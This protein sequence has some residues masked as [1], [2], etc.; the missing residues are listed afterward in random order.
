MTVATFYGVDGIGVVMNN[1]DLDIVVSGVSIPSI[2]ESSHR[3]SAPNYILQYKYAGFKVDVLMEMGSWPYEVMLANYY[4]SSNKV[5]ASIQFENKFASDTKYPNMTDLFLGDDKINGSKYADEL[6]GDDGNDVISGDEGNDTLEGGNG[7]DTL[8]GGPGEDTAVYRRLSTDYIITTSANGDKVIGYPGNYDTL[9]SIE[10]AQFADKTIA[11]VSNAPGQTLDG[12][13]ANDSLT[14]GVSNDAIDGKAGR[15]T[16]N[17][18]SKAAAYAVTPNATSGNASISGPEGSDSLTSI[19]RI[20]FA[21]ACLAFDLEGNAGQIYRLYKAAYA[22]TPDLG[23]LGNWIANLDSGAKTLGQAA[24]EFAASPE[25]NNLYGAHTSNETFVTLLYQNAMGR[26]PDSAGLA[27]YV[28]ALDAGTLTRGAALLSFS[29]SQE[30]QAAVSPKLAGGILYATSEQMLQQGSKLSGT[31]AA[32]TLYGTVWQDTLTGGGGN[33]QLN[34]GANIDTAV[35]SGKRADYS[36]T[37]T[38]TGLTVTGGAEGTDT[39]TDIE[40][41]KFSDGTF[42]FDLAGNAG[43]VYRLYQAALG[44]TPDTPGLSNYLN[45]MENGGMSLQ[46]VTTSLMASTEFSNRYANQ[47]GSKPSDAAFIDLLYQN[48]LGRPA[49]SGGKAAYLNEFSTNG[50]LRETALISFAESSENQAAIIGVIQNGIE[51]N[52]T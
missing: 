36:V 8:N 45:A 15:D 42:A 28:A 27:N 2:L 50:M 33:D 19:E 48:A 29:E 25:F 35:Y 44:R 3:G 46:K 14:G 49:D 21:D 11:L 18:N 34:G 43:Q 20:S 10:Y 30:N 5:L 31:D 1:S 32:D 16:A 40:R 17:Y 39:L 9:T 13:A 7:Y 6:F 23:G 37:Q 41:L 26:N 52:L 22:R 24:S 12:T 4:N 51:L 38:A 47:D